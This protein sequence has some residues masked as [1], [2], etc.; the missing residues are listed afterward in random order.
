MF[1]LTYPTVYSGDLKDN[2]VS[3][4][5]ARALMPNTLAVC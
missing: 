3:P 4:F 1:I 2:F 5:G